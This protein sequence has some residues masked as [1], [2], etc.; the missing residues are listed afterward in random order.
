VEPAPILLVDDAV[1]QE[2]ERDPHRSVLHHV[3][4]IAQRGTPGP[5]SALTQTS[6]AFSGG[7]S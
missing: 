2:I 7:A 3:A 1:A 5:Q 4:R 6:P